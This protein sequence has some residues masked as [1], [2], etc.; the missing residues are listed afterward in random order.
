MAAAIVPPLVVNYRCHF[1]QYSNHAYTLE[2]DELIVLNSDATRKPSEFIQTEASLDFPD[3]L[4]ST[5]K[6]SRCFGQVWRECCLFV[7]PG[8][9]FQSLLNASSRAFS[10]IR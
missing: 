10:F 4:F 5:R 1:I 8:G 7:K 6:A 2:Q 9:Q 3:A